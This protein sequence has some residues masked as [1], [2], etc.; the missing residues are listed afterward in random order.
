MVL[1]CLICCERVNFMTIGEC[2]HKVVCLKCCIK[3][4]SISKNTKCIYCNEELS[5]VAVIDDED[6]TFTEVEIDMREFKDG[7]Y[8]TSPRTK[9]ACFYLDKF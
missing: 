3:M 7:I 9:G 5:R 6:C 2:N 4:R 1:E 8:Y